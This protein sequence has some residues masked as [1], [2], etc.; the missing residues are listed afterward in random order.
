MTSFANSIKLFSCPVNAKLADKDVFR[1]KISGLALEE[2]GLVEDGTGATHFL[3]GSPLTVGRFEHFVVK[4][5]S[6]R[7]VVRLRRPQV[8]VAVEDV[9]L[10]RLD[11]GQMLYANDDALLPLERLIFS[12]Q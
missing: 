4:E 9:L 12:F 2:G 5:L 8:V 6:R 11:N 1:H 10:S 7:L 3:Q